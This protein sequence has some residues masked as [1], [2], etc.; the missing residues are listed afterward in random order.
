MKSLR[1]PDMVFPIIP[2]ILG[3]EG[4]GHGTRFWSNVDVGGFVLSETLD[5]ILLLAHFL[6]GFGSSNPFMVSRAIF[7]FMST[8]QLIISVYMGM[9]AISHPNFDWH[10]LACCMHQGLTVKADVERRSRSIWGN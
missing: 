2:R 1:L 8:D 3:G 9:K 6:S 10:L 5:A 4:G 7:N